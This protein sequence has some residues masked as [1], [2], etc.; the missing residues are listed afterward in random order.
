MY[1]I[2]WLFTYWGICRQQLEMGENVLIFDPARRE[3]S[4]TRCPPEGFVLVFNI[5]TLALQ[6]ERDNI[7]IDSR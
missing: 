1:A 4:V 7:L 5:L 3:R 6:L 2:L